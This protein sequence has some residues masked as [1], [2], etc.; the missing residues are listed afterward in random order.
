MFSIAAIIKLL[1]V[2]GPVTAALPEFKSVYDQIVSTFS[3][4]TDQKTLQE[5]YRELQNENSGGHV[6]LQELLRKAE[7]E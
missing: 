6:R 5:A 7:Q 1:Q 3:S 2:V 4:K